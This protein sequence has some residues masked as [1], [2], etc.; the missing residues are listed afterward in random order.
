MGSSSGDQG[1]AITTDAFGN[2]YTTGYFAGVTDFDPGSSTYT[3]APLGNYDIFISKLDPFGNLI[4]A[5]SM[6]GLN[7]N[8]AYGI[9][10][11]PAGD[12]YIA[13]HFKDTIDVDPG[14][15]TFSLIGFGNEDAFICKLNSS[16]NFIWA[17]QLGGTG[18]DFISSL[19]I[20]PFGNIY[21]AGC[22]DSTVDFDPGAGINNLT[23][24][25]L[26]DAF[27]WKLDA[28][29]SF[30]WA[31]KAGGSG[32]D[33]ASDIC[34]DQFGN[35][36]ST[37]YFS[38]TVDFDPGSA[39]VNLSSTGLDDSFIWGLDAA[40][41]Y[42]C[43]KSIGGPQSDRGYSIVSDAS[44]NLY[45]TGTFASI[46]DLDPGV[47]TYTV[48]SNGLN[49]I[50]ISKLDNSGSFLWGKN[51]GG[52]N[53]DYVNGIV[54]DASN[55]VYT[56]GA[57]QGTVD[58][59]PGATVYNM[60]AIAFS[61]DAFISKLDASGN[62]TFA[63]QLGG[64]N[65]SFARAITVDA[66]SS[67]Y[68]TGYFNGTVDFDPG[69]GTY[70]LS[71]VVAVDIF[72]SRLGY[73]SV[74]IEKLNI[75]ESDFLIYPNPASSHIS[76]SSGYSHLKI[77][78]VEIINYLGQIVFKNNFEDMLD[79]SNLEEGIYTLKLISKDQITQ[80]RLIVAK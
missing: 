59:D 46:A 27:I 34:S 67:I 35:V 19:I 18:N 45:S 70:T 32:S 51:F 61:S 3:L 31:K 7:Y 4:W 13:G 48:S 5:K 9:I 65:G 69:P 36:F 12:V 62:F 75:E 14:P 50:Y 53:Q 23:T 28:S 26:L 15:L 6:G 52:T 17:K 41:N 43:A 40:G 76:F 10:T 42:L 24:S 37:G 38:F 30:V 68:T 20:D 66:L 80:K 16:G 60:T 71:A 8:G 58:F 22:F 72:V 49:D 47:G 64:P 56:T 21:S 29:G 11:D 55:C 54:L 33:V 57:F 2:V 44:G 1:Y 73:G 78:K 39:V 74:K 25:G 79:I 63:L 77:S